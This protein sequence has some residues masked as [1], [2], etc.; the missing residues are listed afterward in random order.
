MEVGQE[1]SYLVRYDAQGVIF[2]VSVNGRVGVWN[3]SWRMMLF[4]MLQDADE[5][6][7]EKGRSDGG[8]SRS[9]NCALLV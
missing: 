4:R 6:F 3:R 9:S 5:E 1:A 8:Y 7:N 2:R